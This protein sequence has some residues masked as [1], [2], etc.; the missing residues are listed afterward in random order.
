MTIAEGKITSRFTIRDKSFLFFRNA[1]HINSSFLRH[2][3]GTH[4]Y[5]ISIPN[6]SFHRLKRQKRDRM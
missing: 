6:R 5:C 4:P 1:V 3:G 2:K